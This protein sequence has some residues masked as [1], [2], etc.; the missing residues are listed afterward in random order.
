MISI[1]NLDLN[2]IN[3]DEPSYK[4]ILIC[5]IRYVTIKIHQKTTSVNTLYLIFGKINGHNEKSIG[6]KYL[7]LDPTNKS[8]DKL[9]N[10]EELW[11]KIR[12]SIVPV[13]DNSYD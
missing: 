9:K 5:Y 12:Y 7:A 8:K 11:N 10:Y 13:I 3:I 2:K 4:N 6:N 1:K